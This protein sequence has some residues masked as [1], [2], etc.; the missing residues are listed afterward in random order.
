MNVRK[1]MG[2]RIELWGTPAEIKKEEED[3][4]KNLSSH[5]IGR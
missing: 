1:S 3:D 2:P 5:T 4:I